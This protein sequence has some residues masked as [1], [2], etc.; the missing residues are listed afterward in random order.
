MCHDFLADILSA[1]PPPPLTTRAS[2]NREKHDKFPSQKSVESIKILQ[3]RTANMTSPPTYNKVHEWLMKSP[4]PP[5][6]SRERTVSPPKS[7][8]KSLP[9]SSPK[10][11]PT[12]SLKDTPPS[13]ELV[14]QSSSLIRKTA[15]IKPTSEN[16]ID[17]HKPDTTVNDDENQR[18]RPLELLDKDEKIQ[19]EGEDDPGTH[20]DHS[21]PTSIWEDAVIL[22][23]CTIHWLTVMALVCFLTGLIIV[24]K[25]GYRLGLRHSSRKRQKGKE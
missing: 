24:W 15:I 13:H 22:I 17:T 25:T 9:K 16:A 8:S 23:L 5:R 14:P 18:D 10:P 2:S 3:I 12:S 1:P 7:P 4:D 19:I 11:S 21:P 6:Q 20:T